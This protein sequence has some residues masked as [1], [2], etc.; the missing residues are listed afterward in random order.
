MHFARV[1]EETSGDRE[2][3]W[4]ER[5]G[6]IS[7]HK[8]R[9]DPGSGNEGFAACA[10]RKSNPDILMVQSAQDR[11]AENASDCLGGT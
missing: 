2:C 8:L 11:M 6:R 10:Y 7:L 1:S 4:I 9:L 3:R 5:G